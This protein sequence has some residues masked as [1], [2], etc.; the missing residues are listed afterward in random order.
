MTQVLGT[1]VLDDTGNLV[2]TPTGGKFTF[3]ATP[4]DPPPVDPPPP[5][6][7]PPPPT[8]TWRGAIIDRD[9]LMALPTS[10]LA[11]DVLLSAAKAQ[12]VDGANL[13]DM[14]NQHD[15]G[16]LA[17]ALAG[18]RL[19][20]DALISKAEACLM[21]AIG[22][23][24]NG[25]SMDVGR[26][27]A[28]YV[29]AADVLGIRSGPIYEWLASFATKRIPHDNTG[30]PMTFRARAWET[31]TNA[32]CQVGLCSVA[33]AVYLR[34]REWLEDNWNAFRRMCGDTSS[35]FQ[36]KPNQFGDPWQWDINNRVGIQQTGKV[37]NGLNVDGA[38]VDMGRSN[39]KPTTSLVYKSDMS[40][41]PW[42]SYNALA[43]AGMVLHRQ[44][45]PA[46][47]VG[48]QALMRA[49]IFLR[50]LARDYNQMGW[51]GQDKK[52]DSKWI[53]HVAYGL[54]LSEYPI[55]LPV[56][57][58]DQVGWADWLYPNPL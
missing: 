3:V 28:A 11:W 33:L 55:T 7:P 42:V 50:R 38:I 21:D 10:G 9:E 58:H 13:S 37:I 39:P 22:T 23:E 52:E 5:P 40:L 15:V 1:I 30:I 29:F 51:W 41:Y 2:I 31:G 47:T 8:T 57:P 44:G 34:D 12:K 4:V 35:P 25:D 27:L 19:G 17:V 54:P 18:V 32:S 46:F 36:L 14:H 24:A 49:A 20:D 16:T 48:N 6:P 53:A 45:Y 56:G 26:S 43:W